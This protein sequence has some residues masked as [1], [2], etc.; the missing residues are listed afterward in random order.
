MRTANE[1][2]NINAPYR[3]RDLH[4]AAAIAASLRKLPALRADDRGRFW[5]Q[6]HNQ[7]EAN[8]IAERYWTGELSVDAQ[9]FVRTLKELKDLLFSQ[10][11]RDGHG[12]DSGTRPRQ[13]TIRPT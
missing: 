9:G 11:R 5:F 8:S 13:P 1:M 10:M 12:D 7:S 2:E 4:E 6:F 3:T